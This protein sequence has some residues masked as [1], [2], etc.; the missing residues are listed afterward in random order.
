M[1]YG[2][3]LNGIKDDVLAMDA[4]VVEALN[5]KVGANKNINFTLKDEGSFNFGGGSY[6]IEFT[7]GI[8]IYYLPVAIHPSYP[9]PQNDKNMTKFILEN[10]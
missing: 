9:F 10:C 7:N 4:E 3:F 8:T 1:F 6:G 2:D 5:D